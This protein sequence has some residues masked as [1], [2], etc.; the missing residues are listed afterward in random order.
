ME[1]NWSRIEPAVFLSSAAVVLLL[2]VFGVADADRAKDVFLGL[3]DWI[4]GTWGWLFV[5]STSLFLLFA[6]WCAIGKRGT[7]RLGPEGEPPA[8][9][10]PSWF[11][12]LFSAG[13]GIGIM[14]Y[15]VAEP[16]THFANPPVGPSGTPEAARQAMTITFFHWGVH[17]WGVYAVM[18][19]AIAYFGHRKGLP[20][21][22]RS[23]LHPLLGDRIHGWLGH[24]VDVFAVFGTL[25]GLATSLGLGAM[26]IN[27]GLARLFGAPE[28]PGFQVALIGVITAGATTSVVLGLDRGIRRLSELN[29]ALATA[30]LLFVAFAGPT[31]AILAA[32]PAG[33]F[34]YAA[35]L[36]PLGTGYRSLGA[37]GWQKGWTLFYWAWWIAWSPFVGMFIARISR[38]RTIREFVLGVLIVPTLVSCVWFTVFGWSALTIDAANPGIVA[39]VEQDIS[40]GIYALLERLP[41]AG[42]TS[43]L[44]A[45]VVAIFFVTS[46]D[47]GSFVV[48][49]LTSGGHPDPPVWQRVFWAVSEGVVAAVLLLAGGLAALQSAAINTGLPFCVILLAVCGGLGRALWSEGRRAS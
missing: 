24:A 19:L 46:S 38:G 23:T 42:V 20:L 30:L 37:V 9:G 17:A 31:W 22:I 39:A 25:F 16:V 49:M 2:L 21:A 44:A 12:M 13:M 41:G 14:F 8:F 35:A 5:G 28:S 45:L 36:V 26:Q 32:F 33:L 10:L 1:T 6:I 29:V 34:D 11:A 18:G 43:L 48:D 47:S 27:T 3:Q 40:M 15:G 7:L 4:V